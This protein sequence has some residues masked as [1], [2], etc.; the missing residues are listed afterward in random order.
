MLDYI[1]HANFIAY[2]QQ[3]WYVRLAIYADLFTLREH[4]ME[5]I[6]F[7]KKKMKSSTNQQRKSKCKNLLYL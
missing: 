6:N 3:N 1:F 2:F 7:K 4:A 5:I